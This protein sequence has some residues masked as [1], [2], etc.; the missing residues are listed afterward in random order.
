MAIRD[1]VSFKAEDSLKCN[2]KTKPDKY[3]KIFGDLWKYAFGFKYVQTIIWS[4]PFLSS[5]G[6]NVI[7]QF[8]LRYMIQA[9]YC[10]LILPN[11][12]RTKNKLKL[13]KEVF[14]IQ[15]QYLQYSYDIG[16]CMTDG[17]I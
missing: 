15:N 5:S 10:I 6:T 11:T 8:Y 16:F 12:V 1:Q 4:F 7:D 17:D 3:C 9:C 2:T 13:S 14:E